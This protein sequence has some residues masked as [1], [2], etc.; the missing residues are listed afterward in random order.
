MSADL[1]HLHH[2][3]VRAFRSRFVVNVVR[4]PTKYVAWKCYQP[5]LRLLGLILSC[6]DLGIDGSAIG[7]TDIKVDP[8]QLQFVRL[9]LVIHIELD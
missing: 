6:W 5:R 4:D 2:H 7:S 1:G 8:E 3:Y 9:E